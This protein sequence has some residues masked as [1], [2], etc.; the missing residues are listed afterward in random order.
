VNAS[1]TVNGA[2]DPNA[3]AS[4]IDKKLREREEQAVIEDRAALIP[5]GAR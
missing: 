1:I 4:A 3:V 5:A 2:G